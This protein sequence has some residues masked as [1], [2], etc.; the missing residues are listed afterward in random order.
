MLLLLVKIVVLQ[1]SGLIFLRL[2]IKYGMRPD[3]DHFI[4]QA[5]LSDKLLTFHHIAFIFNCNQAEIIQEPAEYP[6][7]SYGYRDAH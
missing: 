6:A 5:G 1:I 3:P 2:Q 4:E 7:R